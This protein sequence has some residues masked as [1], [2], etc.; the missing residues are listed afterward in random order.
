MTR[1]TQW[2]K[3]KCNWAEK[4]TS[5]KTQWLPD[6]AAQTLLTTKGKLQKKKKPPCKDRTTLLSCSTNLSNWMLN[7]PL[8]NMAGMIIWVWITNQSTQFSRQQ[9]SIKYCNAWNKTGNNTRMISI[10]RWSRGE[11][12]S[13]YASVDRNSTCMKF[14]RQKSTAFE[15]CSK[16]MVFS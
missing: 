5:F 9:Y 16:G 3:Q 2:F 7:F 6:K 14:L 4:W 10:L 12:T 1:S 15:C 13:H 8:Q 11:E